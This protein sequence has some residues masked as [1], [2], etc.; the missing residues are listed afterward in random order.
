MGTSDVALNTERFQSEFEH[1]EARGRALATGLAILVYRNQN[2]SAEYKKAGW[3][4]R[5]IEIA[6]KSA[7]DFRNHYRTWYSEALAVLKQLLPDRVNDFISHYEPAKSRR[8][9]SWGT[10]VIKDALLGVEVTRGGQTVVDDSAAIPH[11]QSQLAIFA[12]GK[13]RFRSSL[14]EIR[15]LVQADLFDSEIDSARELLRNRFFRAAGAVAGVVLEK[16]LR[17]VCDIRSLKI[18]KKNP[19]I[20]D[21]NELLKS[22][23][24]IDIPGWRHI[25]LLSD[26]RNLCDHNKTAEP[27]AQQV[28][29]LIDGTDK[30]VRTVA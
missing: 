20:S 5:D 29:D 22:N 24:V 8:D 12:A 3:A 25:S 27:T 6:V 23:G 17:H 7:L 30:I 2:V 16:H 15:Q 11:F 9:I 21:L 18:L 28:Q 26:I 1:L 13:S 19:G 10:Y 14:F 4:G